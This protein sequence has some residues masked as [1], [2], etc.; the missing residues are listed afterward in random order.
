MPPSSHDKV[1]KYSVS[2]SLRRIDTLAALAI[3]GVGSLI[4]LAVFGIFVFI[5]VQTLPLFKGASVKLTETTVIPEG[6]YV[7]LGV[8]E[9]SE[10]PFLMTDRGAF[11]FFPLNQPNENIV[12]QPPELAGQKL[13][14]WNYNQ[15][16][17]TVL[18][19]ME[20]G[21]AEFLQINY[22]PTFD[23]DLKR[24]IKVEITAEAPFTIGQNVTISAIDFDQTDR[25]RTIVAITKSNNITRCNILQFERRF[26]LLGA[27][28]WIMKGQADVSAE[29]EGQ[30]INAIVGGSGNLVV[31]TD[32]MNNVYVFEKNARQFALHQTFTSFDTKDEI[33]SID[34]LGGRRTLIL[35]SAS[36]LLISYIP[37]PDAETEGLLYSQA[38]TFKPLKS[39]ASIFASSN[40]NRTF[41]VADGEHIS[42]RYGT[43]G[44]ILWK[45]TFTFPPQF[46]LIGSRYQSL[47]FFGQNEI[48]RYA[49]N[50][51]H[52][53]ASLQGYFGKIR[54]E[55]QAEPRY[56]WQSTGGGDAFEPK[57]SIVP[58]I[59]GSFK[60]TFYAMLFA[61]P[62]ALSAA[63]Y[64]AH[65]LRPSLK[66]LIKPTMEIMASLPSVV[67]GFLAALWLAPIID[68]RI[69][70]VLLGLAS[71]PITA[72]IM[73]WVWMRKPRS[74]SRITSQGNEF[75]V[76]LP[77]IFCAFCLAW[78]LGPIV[79]QFLFT[80]T[81]PTTGKTI[82][83]FRLWWE[84][85][86]GLRF[87][88]RNA[89]VIGFMMGFAVIPIIFTLSEDALSNIPNSLV[90]GSLA[91]G[92]SRWDTARRIVFPLA[93]PG[94]FSA[95]MI[96][97]GRAIGETM[98]VV[99]ATGNTPVTDL[100]IFSGMRT[101][102][103]NIA[104]ELPDAPVEPVPST[105]Y[106]TLFLGAMVLFILTFCVN[107]LA[108]ITRM[109]IRRKYG[110]L[111]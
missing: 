47:I 74:L 30:P 60:G 52:P 54:Y 19:G 63:L 90:S 107:T 73:G 81:D 49:L 111:P 27:G 95:L 15:T 105:L 44:E 17:E 80:V 25:Q 38:N 76:L 92:A 40:L 1:D 59:A 101:L 18:V 82:S 43:T 88:Q 9:W 14:A 46:G 96:G 99:M 51:P 77:L 21:A 35:S 33:A 13:T 6:N 31:V 32:D 10:L 8:D 104:I 72:L 79:E 57:L 87:E 24:T 69:P 94:I 45:D 56:M 84:E 34:W 5:I 39:G 16:S 28:E 109:R 22:E 23:D 4:I 67:L 11:H 58:L 93:L 37:H 48:H 110:N 64:S 106:R 102:A 7:L 50:D 86:V 89:L 61:I 68:D 53:E 29:I 12:I 97:L 65:F 103:A 78:W 66:R 83:D 26:G 75:I 85:S 71:I 55:G 70:S 36:G 100:N 41:L 20:N 62:I 2:K 98:I 91:L 108:E 3:K 42:L